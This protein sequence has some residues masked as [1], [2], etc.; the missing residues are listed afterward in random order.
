MERRIFMSWNPSKAEAEE[1]FL[2]QKVTAKLCDV[3]FLND[4]EWEAVQKSE[5][6]IRT[7]APTIIVTRGKKGGDVMMGGKTLHY[8]ARVVQ[9]VCET[10]AGDAFAAGFVGAH[11]RGE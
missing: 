8:E 9:A 7:A 1:M 10:G 6:N 11:L 4:Q 5:G 2:R 3:L